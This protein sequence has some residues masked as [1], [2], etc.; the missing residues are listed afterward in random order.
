MIL[1]PHFLLALSGIQ[2][3][4]RVFRSKKLTLTVNFNEQLL[5]LSREVRNLQLIF[6]RKI[7][8]EILTAAEKVELRYPTALALKYA[9]QIYNNALQRVPCPLLA[10]LEG[11]L[12][13]VR[14]LM[15]KAFVVVSGSEKKEVI[16]I[17][18]VDRSQ[19]VESCIS[20]DT[21][22]HEYST[23]QEWVTSVCNACFNVERAV[24]DL[25]E[26]LGV[27]EQQLQALARNHPD[28]SLQTAKGESREHLVQN[29]GRAASNRLDFVDRS[30]NDCS[31]THNLDGWATT[32]NKEEDKNQVNYYKELLSKIYKGEVYGF[33]AYIDPILIIKT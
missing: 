8:N 31:V 22:E 21:Q 2:K 12:E 32:K 30:I 26:K 27:I 33:I 10:L 17:S 1:D 5:I 19:S 7:P 13:V 25:H 28:S 24:D 29:P 6:G 16:S 11:P 9:L 23:F 15:K 14:T 18:S 3:A 4:R 20:W